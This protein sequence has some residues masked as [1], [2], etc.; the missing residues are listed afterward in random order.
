M[1]NFPV[2]DFQKVIAFPLFPIS[3][4]WGIISTSAGI[5]PQVSFHHPLPTPSSIA[6]TT[7]S[8]TSFHRLAAVAGLEGM[9]R[10]TVNTFNMSWLLGKKSSISEKDEYSSE[11]CL[12]HLQNLSKVHIF[13]M[14]PQFASFS[15]LVLRLLGCL[16]PTHLEEGPQERCFAAD[17]LSQETH[18]V[19]L[20]LAHPTLP[21]LALV[22]PSLMFL[23]M[24]LCWKHDSG[25]CVPG[26]AC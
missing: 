17:L 26:S 9:G 18:R 11:F 12:M 20:A 13:Q 15:S 1:E 3:I 4:F 22:S 21:V 19:Q 23:A 7:K 6:F 16:L 25:H 2:L 8:I 14:Q 5:Y 10:M 24:G